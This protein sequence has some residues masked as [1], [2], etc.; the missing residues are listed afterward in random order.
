[1]NTPGLLPHQTAQTIIDNVNQARTNIAQAFALL[2]S[3]KVRLNA[4]LGDGRATHYGHLWPLPISDYHLE[5]TA[6]EIDR[7]QVRNAWEYLL[8]QS[9][10]MHYMT[11]TRQQELTQQLTNGALPALTVENVL[12]TFD[13]LVGQL[14]TLLLESIQEVF[15]WLR[16]PPAIRGAGALKTN[17]PWHIGPKVILSWMVEEDTWQHG[18][19]LNYNREPEMRSL[20][21]VLSL[22]DGQGVRQSPHDLISCL[23]TALQHCPPGKEVTVPYVRAKPYRNGNLHVTF[24]RPDLVDRLN[25][26]GGDGTLSPGATAPLF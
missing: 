5:E 25:Q 4:V 17:H 1:M 26:L 22:L 12:S 11:A 19:R 14:N 7:H 15:R 6:L 24:T 18:F 16:P 20:G 9:G 3:A 2:A 23:R 10:L 13:G 21:N 8:T